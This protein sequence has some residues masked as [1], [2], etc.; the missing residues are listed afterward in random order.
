MQQVTEQPFRRRDKIQR[1]IIVGLTTVLVGTLGCVSSAL[2][3]WHLDGK[4]WERLEQALIGGRLKSGADAMIALGFG[5]KPTRTELYRAVSS[6]SG[7]QDERYVLESWYS[8]QGVI[9]IY[10]RG[11]VDN[12]STPHSAYIV[13]SGLAPGGSAERWIFVDKQLLAQHIEAAQHVESADRAAD[14]AHYAGE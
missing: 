5:G 10:S 6:E 4:R 9:M 2:A 1:Y 8:R 11:D 13:Y 7:S 3:S 14:A 12:K